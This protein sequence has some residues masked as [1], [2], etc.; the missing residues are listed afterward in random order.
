MIWDTTAI[1]RR[2]IICCVLLSRLVEKT[3]QLPP[4][5]WDGAAFR[6]SLTQGT[7]Q[8][9]NISRTPLDRFRISKGGWSAPVLLCSVAHGPT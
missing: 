5:A 9:K 1:V 4:A 3:S 6:Y 2:V 7:K 8:A